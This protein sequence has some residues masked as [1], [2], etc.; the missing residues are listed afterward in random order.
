[1]H[2]LLRSGQ[3]WC[4]GLSQRFVKK[5]KQKTVDEL[6]DSTWIKWKQLCWIGGLPLGS[7]RLLAKISVPRRSCIY[8]ITVGQVCEGQASHTTQRWIK[9]EIWKISESQIGLRGEMKKASSKQVE[10]SSEGTQRCVYTG[11]RLQRPSDTSVIERHH[12]FLH[13]PSGL[14]FKVQKKRS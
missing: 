5:I 4:C 13:T 6:W 8:G 12:M 14:L 9:P 11:S 2:F 1:M 3:P 10:A 7:I